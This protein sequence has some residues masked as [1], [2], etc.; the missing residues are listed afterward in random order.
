MR[1]VAPS[2]DPVLPAPAARTHTAPA[3]TQ[4]V[5]AGAVAAL[6]VA[7]LVPPEHVADGPVICPFRRLTGL[8][9]PGCGL[10]RS[11]VYLVHGW[12]REAFLAHPFGVVAAVAVVALAGAMAI[13]RF[14]RRPAPSLDRLVRRP[15][16]VALAASWL[17]FAVVRMVLTA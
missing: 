1:R 7:C 2:A 13:A 15:W 11:W 5:V 17:A 14:R 4:V 9:C 8:S 16:A 10:T 12:W 3:S 6:G